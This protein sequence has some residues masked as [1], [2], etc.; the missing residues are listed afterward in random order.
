MAAKN[1]SALVAAVHKIS[2]T[3][4]SLPPSS[5]HTK[6]V[7]EKNIVYPTAQAHT[8]TVASGRIDF[9]HADATGINLPRGA[10]TAL[11]VAT[12]VAPGNSGCYSS[13]NEGSEKSRGLPDD[14]SVS[15][16]ASDTEFD[17]PQPKDPSTVASSLQEINKLY[18]SEER[19]GAPLCDFM[20]DTI[21]VMGRQHMEVSPLD[22]LIARQIRP[23][24]VDLQLNQVT[25]EIYSCG[26]AFK[27]T[28]PRIYKSLITKP[29]V[30]KTLL[31]GDNMEDQM[32][33]LET[34]EKPQK[35]LEPEKTQKKTWASSSTTTK[36]FQPYGKASPKAPKNGKG[37]P[38]PTVNTTLEKPACSKKKWYPKR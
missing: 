27:P 7:A 23:A 35:A 30:S 15:L 28:T 20:V 33:S 19:V 26:D 14:D 16:I 9:C 13:H 12:I 18:C 31:F 24:D 38:K 5:A 34:K 6:L 17:Y 8:S 10:D 4:T 3:L 37:F 25:E 29:G 32:R 1:A 21:N 11:S 2:E 22:A 36:R